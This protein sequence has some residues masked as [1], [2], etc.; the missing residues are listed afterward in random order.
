M[1]LADKPAFFNAD[2][3]GAIV[4]STISEINCS[5]F[6]RCNVLTKC[7]GTPSTGIM[8]GKLISVEVV[9]ES[10]IFAFSAASFNLC[11]AIGSFLKSRPSSFLNSS[12][13]HEI[14]VSSTSSPPR[15]VSPSVDKTSKTPSP[16]SRMETSCVPPPKSKTTIFWSTPFLSS[17]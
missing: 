11:N 14:I 13:N 15:W 17:P 12:A 3:H 9:E 5:N 7:F 6:A 2:L 10:S 8:Y 16:S 4:L 1:S